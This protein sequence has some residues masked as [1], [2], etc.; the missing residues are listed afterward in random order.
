MEGGIQLPVGSRIVGPKCSGAG[1]ANVCAKDVAA[2]KLHRFSPLLKAKILL[3]ISS[4]PATPSNVP[5]P[6]GWVKEPKTA[7]AGFPDARFARW[8]GGAGGPAPALQI[9]EGFSSF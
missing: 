1:F 7:A 3:R 8:G 6:A 4:L 9:H 2:M 5:H